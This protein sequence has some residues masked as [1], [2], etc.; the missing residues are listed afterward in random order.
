M[1]TKAASYGAAALPA[2]TSS[3]ATPP[4]CHQTPQ[5][6][7]TLSTV[8]LNARQASGFPAYTGE[9]EHVHILL[10]YPPAV[11]LSDLIRVL[12]TVSSGRIQ[13]E[14]H[15]EI[16]HFLWGKRFWTG[17]YCVMSAWAGA[18]AEIIE[19][20]NATY[21]IRNGQNSLLAAACITILT[22]RVLRGFR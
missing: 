11:R 2:G 4:V 1:S 3:S 13:T 14:C 15:A 21:T 6:S 17:S 9:A 5:N 19:P 20:L 10:E 7:F 16:Q 18:H 8:T 22:Y 12:K